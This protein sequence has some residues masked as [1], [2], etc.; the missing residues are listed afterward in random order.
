M[1]SSNSL[2]WRTDVWKVVKWFFK[3]SAT[4]AGRCDDYQCTAAGVLHTS[5][6]LILN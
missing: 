1:T 3:G 4:A 5:I 6:P 2:G